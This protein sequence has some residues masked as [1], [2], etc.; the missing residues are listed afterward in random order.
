MYVCV[1]VYMCVL[2]VCVCVCVCV[3]FSADWASGAAAVTTHTGW[4]CLPWSRACGPA[5][6]RRPSARTCRP[7]TRAR[8]TTHPVHAP[9][10][11][12]TL[13]ACPSSLPAVRRAESQRSAAC[14]CVGLPRAQGRMPGRTAPRRAQAPG[15][16]QHAAGRR[17]RCADAARPTSPSEHPSPPPLRPKP[18]PRWPAGL[19][20][21]AARPTR[22]T[23]SA[24]QRHGLAATA[25]APARRAPATR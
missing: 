23:Q 4:A 19:M 14:R 18:R 22:P 7:A 21:T 9:S 16:A 8:A 3:L 25:A 24:R 12:G 10:P 17:R 13:P 2:C 11:T 1:Y 20:P 5:S 15:P 6:P